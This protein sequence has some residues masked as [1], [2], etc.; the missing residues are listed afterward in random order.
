MD[1]FLG[2]EN[3]TIFFAAAILVVAFIVWSQNLVENGVLVLLAALALL[4]VALMGRVHEHESDFEEHETKG[5]IEGLH[6]HPESHEEE[7]RGYP[8]GH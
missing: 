4:A 2:S 6:E 5:E 7:A 8:A 3:Q 1:E